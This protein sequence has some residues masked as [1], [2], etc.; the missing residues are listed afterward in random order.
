MSIGKIHITVGNLSFMGEGDQAWVSSELDKL[1]AAMPK[2]VGHTGPPKTAQ[3]LPKSHE[4]D[5]APETPEADVKGNVE[6]LASFLKKHDA[7]KKQTRRFL[8]TARWLFLRGN[9]TVVTRDV[10][11][12]LDEHHQKKVTNAGQCLVNLCRSGFCE[13]S[14]KGFYITPEGE[15]QLENKAAPEQ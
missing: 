8:A 6:S 12:A 1:L 9:T 14:G 3:P 4:K 11:K 13:R 10:T 2:L 5:S 15:N 7:L